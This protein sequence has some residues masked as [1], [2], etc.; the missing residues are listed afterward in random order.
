MSDQGRCRCKGKKHKER[1]TRD[2]GRS[3]S[4]WLCVVLRGAWGEKALERVTPV[5]TQQHRRTGVNGGQKGLLE[6]ICRDLARSIR[7]REWAWHTE[8]AL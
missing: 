8:H 6:S 3:S 5:V 1:A 2:R 4:F 7:C